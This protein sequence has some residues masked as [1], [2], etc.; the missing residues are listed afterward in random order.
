MLQTLIGGE[1]ADARRSLPGPLAGSVA[2]LRA[3]VKV[4]ARVVVHAPSPRELPQR[5]RHHHPLQRQARHRDRVVR[6]ARVL[7]P[8]EIPGG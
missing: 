5:E 3:A 2:V 6:Q 8:L 7:L 1:D 4:G